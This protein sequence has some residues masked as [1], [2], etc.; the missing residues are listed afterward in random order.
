[1]FL[2]F[3]GLVVTDPNPIKQRN[4]FQEAAFSLFLLLFMLI[5]AKAS[6]HF[7]ANNLRFVN[8]DENFMY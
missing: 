7:L 4:P 5:Q 6:V 1:M 3:I 8:S 2:I